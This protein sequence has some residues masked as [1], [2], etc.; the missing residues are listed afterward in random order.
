MRLG[1]YL[2]GLEG[3]LGALRLLRPNEA[4]ALGR[5]YP[6]DVRIYAKPA[7]G[8]NL[9]GARKGRLERQVGRARGA[10]L[11]CCNYAPSCGAKSSA[12]GQPTSFT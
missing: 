3:A 4:D 1:T 5:G 10:H 6:H 2:S 11:W 8:G 9:R 7:P 12:W